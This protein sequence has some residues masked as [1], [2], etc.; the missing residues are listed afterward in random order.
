MICDTSG[1]FSTD[2]SSDPSIAVQQPAHIKTAKV[3]IT[4]FII[5]PG[6]SNPDLGKM[7][8]PGE[9]SPPVH[10]ELDFIVFKTDNID[11]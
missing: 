2:S 1:G 3:G 11:S 10:D 6:S 8:Y 4:S 5:Q 9:Q 7:G